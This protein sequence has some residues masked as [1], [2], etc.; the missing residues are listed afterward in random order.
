[1]TAVRTTPRIRI[2][3]GVVGVVVALFLFAYP[4]QSLFAQQTQ[5]NKS[6]AQLDT[7]ERQ[8][9]ELQAR[10]KRLATAAE[11]ERQAR[12]RFNMVRPNEK[13]YSVVLRGSDTTTT[14][15]T[16]DQRDEP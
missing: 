7:L 8:N 13:A 14:T 5:V 11:I 12:E 16:T 6:Q 15:P 4:T 2:A 1:M 9:R 10:A 3:A